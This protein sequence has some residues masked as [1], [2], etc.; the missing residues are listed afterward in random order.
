MVISTT[1]GSAVPHELSR[2]L[3][4]AGLHHAAVS[5]IL[6]NENITQESKIEKLWKIRDS[7]AAK[8]RILD[9]KLESAA[10]RLELLSNPS[11]IVDYPINPDPLCD[12]DAATVDLPIHHLEQD[13]RAAIATARRDD[14]LGNTALGQFTNQIYLHSY[15]SLV[16]DSKTNDEIRR[17]SVSSVSTMYNNPNFRQ[18]LESSGGE[19]DWLI[20]ADRSPDH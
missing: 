20:E 4:S 17:R 10:H 13:I 18:A 14:L 6:A 9:R 12:P 3:C 15:N 11:C 5:D 7:Q 2:F 19:A 1:S 16:Q 8:R